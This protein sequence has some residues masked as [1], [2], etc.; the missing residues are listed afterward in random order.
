[1]FVSI[2]DLS[3]NHSNDCFSEKTEHW[4]D[5]DRYEFYTLSRIRDMG[6]SAKTPDELKTVLA[7]N[8]IIPSLTVDEYEFERNYIR[9]LRNRKLSDMFDKI[10]DKEAYDLR[11]R[12]Y[13]ENNNID[14]F[15]ELKEF[16]RDSAVKWCIENNVRYR[17]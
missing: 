2:R 13:M 17:K 15:D 4:F 14:Y 6:Y 16:I 3:L 12:V 1:M 7:E 9:S 10:G 5:K 11:F 8:N